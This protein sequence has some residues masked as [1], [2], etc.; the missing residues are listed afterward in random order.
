MAPK[1]IKGALVEMLEDLSTQNFDKFRSELLDRREEPRVRR[2]KV[3]GKNVLEIADVLVSTFT[4]AKAPGVALEL[5]KQ[6]CC[7]EDAD[8]LVKVISGLSSPPGSSEAA[9][10]S[11]GAAG[12]DTKAVDKHFVDK[13]QLQLIN[14]VSHIAPILD[15]LLE[16]QVLQP[17]SYDDIWVLP[18]SQG[19][20]RKLYSGCLKSGTASKDIFYDILVK[21]EK[22]LIEDLKKNN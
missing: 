18:T 10:P 16:R 21:N 9:R 3:E 7:H 5:L 22:Y 8:R 2:N 11:A 13:H 17:E 14:R 1:T 4:E 15:E 6:I 19:K 20:M 12:G